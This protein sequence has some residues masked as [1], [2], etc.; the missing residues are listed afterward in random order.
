VKV[1]EQKLSDEARFL[2]REY[3]LQVA[4]KEHPSAVID[5]LVDEYADEDGHIGR[6]VIIRS[7]E[8]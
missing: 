3:A 8:A 4:R 1:T 7:A 5:V 6:R 2:V